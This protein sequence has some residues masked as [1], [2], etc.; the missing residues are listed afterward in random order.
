MD[1][2]TTSTPHV[3]EL[4]DA[5]GP[6]GYDDFNLVMQ[7]T[8]TQVDWAY[9]VWDDLL[10][11]C[12]GKD[13]H[14]RAIAA[15]V[16]CNLAK[17]DPERRMLEDF[18]QVF[19]V[20]RDPKFVTARHALQAAWKV[21]VVSDAHRALVVDRLSG[22]F[23]DCAAEKNATLIRHDI[24]V[25][26]AKVYHTT[27]DEA[28]EQRALALIEAEGDLKYRKKYASAWRAAA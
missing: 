16:L 22:R 5:S 15:Q 9:D 20:T 28:V 17:S 12:R 11:A 13:A 6:L 7:A 24:V 21:G 27:N 19:A 8:D 25:A 26:L 23:H 2:I 1:K 10:A 18:D 3:R 4:L 14:R